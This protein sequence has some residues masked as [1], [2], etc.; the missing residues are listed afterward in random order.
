MH[1]PVRGVE[2]DELQSAPAHTDEARGGRHCPPL[3]RAITALL[4]FYILYIPYYHSKDDK[5]RVV[6]EVTEVTVL[7][8]PP[9]SA[10]GN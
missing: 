6:T 1:T 10:D 5:S 8:L 3:G 4:F 9:L 2:R 7:F